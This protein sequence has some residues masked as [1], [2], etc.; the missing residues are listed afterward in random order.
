MCTTAD[1]TAFTGPHPRRPPLPVAVDWPAVEEWLGLRLPHDYRQLAGRHG[2]LDFGD[3]LWI[4]VP[5]AQEGRFD[6]GDWLRSTHH[7]ARI[8][9]R[10]LPADER[11]AVH[12]EP[13]GLLAWGKS[14]SSDMFFWDTGSS[15]DPDR[16]TVVV[17]HRGAVPGS[18]LRPWHRYDLTLTEY[19]RH[20]VRAEWSLPSPPGPLIGPLPGTIART[21]FLTTA[22]PG[23]LPRRTFPGSPTN[24]ATSRCGPAPAWTRCA[25]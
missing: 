3:Y 24:N 11:P 25:C 15:P 2:P 14:R 20:T 19:L 9:A 18:G 1:S 8:D 4:H 17:R 10:A 5:C 16:W 22:P 7:R 23:H 6:Y 12:P 21:A 13:G